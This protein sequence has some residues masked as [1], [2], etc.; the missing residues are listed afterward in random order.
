M[1]GDTHDLSYYAKCMMGGIMACGLTHT[2]IVPL[3][4]V[5]CKNQV[6]KGWSASLGQGLGQL[7]AEGSLT[8]GWFPT[9]IGYSLQGFGKFGFYEIFKDVYK[10]IVGEENAQKYRRIGWSVASG[11]AEVIADTLLCP[12]ETIK[13]KMQISTAEN[14]YPKSF[15]PAYNKFVGENGTKSL[16]NILPPLW[17][18]Q[19]PYTIVKFVAFEQIVELFYSKVFTKPRSEYSKGQQLSVTFLSGYLAGVFCALVS[20]PAD[21]M[22]SKMNAPEFKGKGVSEIYAKIGFGGLWTG[23][24]TRIIMIGTLTGLQ[25]WIYDSFK[26]AVGLQA[27]GGSSAPVAKKH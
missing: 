17:G 18:R 16:Y 15:L 20:H 2:A 11:C 26:T 13:V 12:F 23:L 7:K 5:K 8:L 24:V 9:L 25:W 19:I 3:D 22:V 4:V 10:G 6:T 14:A 1:G 27:S 21:T